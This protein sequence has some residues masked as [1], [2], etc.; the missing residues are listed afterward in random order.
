MK[1]IV[2]V[3]VG[4][5][6]LAAVA[7]NVL[8]SR[9]PEPG[10]PQEPA[11]SY[12]EAATITWR[13]EAV[14]DT[15]RSADAAQ[16]WAYLPVAETSLQRVQDIKISATEGAEHT[17][18]R[19]GDGTQRVRLTWLSLGADVTATVSVAADL[20]HA[21][22]PNPSLESDLATYRV[23]PEE[24]E[25]VLREEGSSE[26]NASDTPVGMDAVART[27][28]DPSLMERVTSILKKAA[29]AERELP[30]G[31]EPAA[32]SPLAADEVGAIDE[33]VD[34]ASLLVL[35]ARL[36]SVP[37]R[38]VTGF[39]LQRD[40]TEA[41]ADDLGNWVEVYVDERW[42]PIEAI[43]GKA[44]GSDIRLI[45]LTVDSGIPTGNSPRNGT[46]AILEP[47]GLRA[48]IL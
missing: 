12:P 28:Q 6:V 23:L 9:S 31:S 41:H 13:I 22:E 19:L 35:L 17:I 24:V 33:S 29:L 8:L 30:S 37:A 20:R 7:T 40:Q 42:R 18:Y 36:Y 26:P 11:R 25:R 2:G 44:F 3:C 21:D 5:A 38:R 32:E 10:R 43:S 15:G 1:K 34:R 46:E 27:L 47:V 39:V 45:A 48:R 4:V 14:N 16:L